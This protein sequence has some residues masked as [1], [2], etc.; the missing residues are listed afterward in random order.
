[1][2]VS[3]HITRSMQGHCTGVF[4]ERRLASQWWKGLFH[5]HVTAA[6]FSDI[7][8]AWEDSSGPAALL[9]NTEAPCIRLSL[10]L[11]QS[12]WAEREGALHA[13]C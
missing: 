5:T 7:L 6:F 9:R 4:A 12:R 3:T 2:H 11:G 1:M 13:G 10:C 8:Q